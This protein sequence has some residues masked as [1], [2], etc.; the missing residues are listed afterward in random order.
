MLGG[1]YKQDVLIKPGAL[2]HQLN[3]WNLTLK[4]TL[5]TSEQERENGQQARRAWVEALPWMDVEKL[6]FLD[7]AWTSTSMTRCCGRAHKGKRCIAS[8]PHG[9]WKTTIF[10]GAL[11][12][13]RLIVWRAG[14]A[15]P[16]GR[17]RPDLWAV[18]RSGSKWVQGARSASSPLF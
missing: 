1:W 9:H 11:S 17:K 3:K 8:A 6:V 16:N 5:H 18:H 10:E 12:R 2:W 7:E 14:G 15:C 13:R 4:K